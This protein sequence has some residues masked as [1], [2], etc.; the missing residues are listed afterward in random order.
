MRVGIGITTYNRIACLKKTLAHN[1]PAYEGCRVII[2]DDGSTDGT[3]EFLET[4]GFDFIT[5]E[6]A[7]VAT[8]KNKL[9][10]LLCDCDYI[11]QLDDDIAVH[12]GFVDL[13][14]N[15]FLK[16]GIEHFTFN[17][18]GR[19]WGGVVKESEF[20]GV[21]IQHFEFAGGAFAFHTKRAV[22]D[23][24]ETWSHRD[25]STK[26][27]RAA[28]SGWEQVNHI[29]GSEEFVELLS[30]SSSCADRNLFMR[31]PECSI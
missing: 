25:L 14:I 30:V 31:G 15:A 26:I 11:F 23:G 27:W 2:S 9:F 7:G 4:S 16:T 21:T 18:A 13:Y 24:Y 28:M 29:K 20:D 12:K 17:P 22:C 19:Q 6:N 5:G 8:S 3:V 1:M 10:H